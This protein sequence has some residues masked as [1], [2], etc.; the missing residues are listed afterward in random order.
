M[1]APQTNQFGVRVATFRFFKSFLD[2]YGVAVKRG[3]AYS[4]DETGC[5]RLN[6]PVMAKTAGLEPATFKVAFGHL[7]RRIGEI[8]SKHEPISIDFSVGTLLSDTDGAVE[9]VFHDVTEER[10]QK[11]LDPRLLGKAKHQTTKLV[12]TALAPVAA[13]SIT[14]PISELTL[15]LRQRYTLPSSPGAAGSGGS[16][17]AA[18]VQKLFPSVV[19]ED[20]KTSAASGGKLDPI[21][22]PRQARTLTGTSTLARVRN[23]IEMKRSTYRQ[24]IWD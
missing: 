24:P 9:F 20:V 5:I 11:V 3:R 12:P 17:T 6:I 13:T 10:A 14:S 18:V 2:K 23:I 1:R 7:F 16:G 19:G 22:S 4:D 8:L 21:T 15:Q